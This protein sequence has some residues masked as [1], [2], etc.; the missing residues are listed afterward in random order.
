MTDTG[1]RPAVLL[2]VPGERLDV[3]SGGTH[4]HINPATG[5]VD[6]KV[7]LAGPG[8]VDRAVN[9]AD[10]AFFDW[11]RTRSEERRRLLLRLADLIE[12]NAEEFGRRGTMDNGQRGSSRG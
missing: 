5:V 9:A 6:A 3:G 8:E 7:A 11:K 4:G 1:N 10:A 2:H 12:A